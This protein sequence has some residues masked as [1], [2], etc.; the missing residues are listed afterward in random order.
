MFELIVNHFLGNIPEWVWPFMAGAGFAVFII[1]GIAQHIQPV[2][3]YALIARPVAVVVMIV[4]I[5]FYG[6]AGVL[7]IKKQALEEAQHRVEI[8]EQASAD[9][10]KQL[11]DTLAAN[12]HLIRGRGYGVDQIIKQDKTIINADCKQINDRAWN[13]YNRAVSNI[14]SA[15]RK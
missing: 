5:F 9:A 2:R 4:G 15:E 1:A 13:D 14:G 8:A 11:A 7:A 6:G 12:E 10:A 3:I